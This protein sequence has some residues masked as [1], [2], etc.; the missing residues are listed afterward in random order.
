M[1]WSTYVDTLVEGGMKYAGVY[2]QDG[3]V[4]AE[5]PKTKMSQEQILA[6]VNIIKTKQPTEVVVDGKKWVFIRADN[7][8]ATFKTKA[9]D[10]E[11]SLLFHIAM[12]GQAVIL[13]GSCGPAERATVKIV[14]DLREYLA[15]AGL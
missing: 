6:I 4:W 11:P 7:N 15:R 2:G 10:E 8:E 14:G 12:S 9:T 5:A 1:S 3:N 13:A